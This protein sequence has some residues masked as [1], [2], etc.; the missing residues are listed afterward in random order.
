MNQFK[1]VYLALLLVL[2]VYRVRAQSMAVQVVN[3]DYPQL[4]QLYNQQGNPLEKQKAHYIFAI[5][6]STFMRTNIDVL[7]PLIAQFIQALPDGDQVTLIRKS[8]TEN[9]DYV[10]GVINL[11]VSSST[12]NTMIN[13]I[14]SSEFN[15][16]PA[17][18]D[19]FLMTKKILDAIMNPMS[20]GLVFV[21]MFTDFEYWTAQNGYDK[22]KVKW[23]ELKDKFY[24]FLELTKGDQSRVVMPYAFYFKDET[25]S[26]NDYRPELESIFGCKLNNPP[27][28]DAAVLRNFFQRMETNALVYRLKFRVFQDLNRVK[29]VSY[30]ALSDNDKLRLTTSY[31]NDNDFPLF[32]SYR[33]EV[34][35]EP[36]CL[37]NAFMKADT[38]KLTFNDAQ[39]LYSRNRNYKPILPHFTVLHG[40]I[41]YSIRPLCDKYEKELKMLNGLD[42]SLKLNYEKSFEFEKSLPAGWYF[43][44]I[45]PAWLDILILALLLLWGICLLITFLLNK[46]GNIYRPWSVMVTTDDGENQEN[47]SHKFSKAKKVSVTPTA[48]GILDGSNWKFDIITVDGPIYSFWKPRGYYIK[49]GGPMTIERKGKTRAL[50]KEAYRVAPLKN[51]GSGCKLKF[52]NN[53]KDYIVKIQ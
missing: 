22:D 3:H 16:I 13:T 37:E 34:T 50:P 8:S 51:W 17:G 32:S 38:K 26:R 35:D 7:K 15:V 23:N 45:L 20:E 49:R 21:F 14:N 12:R 30:I 6:V 4:M 28:G 5:D 19:G 25:S 40:K 52:K 10:G 9:T 46:F 33:C 2:S 18:S 41:A 24:P 31:A 44:H 29:M 36:S 39:L 11:K 47:F 27:T 42:E 1:N 48:F 53:N 43:S